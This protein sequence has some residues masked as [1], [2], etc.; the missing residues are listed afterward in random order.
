VLEATRYQQDQQSRLAGEIDQIV[1]AIQLA[2]W[3]LEALPPNTRFAYRDSEPPHYG[4][5]ELVPIDPT[6]E[7]EQST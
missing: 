4:M 7:K 3:G 2:E 1:M 5:P 6:K